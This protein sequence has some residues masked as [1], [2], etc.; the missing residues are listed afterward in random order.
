M[1]LFC[2]LILWG[3]V[4]KWRWWLGQFTLR[5]LALQIYLYF[6]VRPS[7]EERRWRQRAPAPP[8]FEEG[9]VGGWS[10]GRGSIGG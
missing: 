10:W 1:A 7:S 8:P 4:R 9:G 3:L 2:F 5:C 6:G